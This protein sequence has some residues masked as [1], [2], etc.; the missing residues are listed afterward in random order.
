V[1][2]GPQN[3]CR[4]G[5]WVSLE[6]AQT[7]RTHS[8]VLIRVGEKSVCLSM[9][10]AVSTH[11]WGKR[12]NSLSLSLSLNLRFVL[13][14]THVCVCVCVCVCA[15][16]H[17]CECQWRPEELEPSGVGVAGGCELPSVGTRNQTL[18]LCRSSKYSSLLSPL[19]SS[20]ILLTTNTVKYCPISDA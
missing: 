6:P 12:T 4:G 15:Y 8:P 9:L 19:S 2:G 17:E 7:S 13:F 1:C 10:G 5:S 11:Y 20:D 3:S 14:L 18:V 16:A